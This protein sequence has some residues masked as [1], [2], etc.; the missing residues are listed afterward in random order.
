MCVLYITILTLDIIAIIMAT[1]EI[2]D[3]ENSPL[4]TCY[5]ISNFIIDAVV[6]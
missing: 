5:D 1:R 3:G 4:Y 2:F 6:S